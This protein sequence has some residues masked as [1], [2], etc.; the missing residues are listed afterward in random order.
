MFENMCAYSYSNCYLYNLCWSIQSLLYVL[1]PDQ[2]IISL[3]WTVLDDIIL[4]IGIGVAVTLTT[5][6][7]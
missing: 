1:W 3:I 5:C 7:I 6:I 4:S 2:V